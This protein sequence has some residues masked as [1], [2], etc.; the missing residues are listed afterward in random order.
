MLKSCRA[1]P[2]CRRYIQYEFK[3]P[4]GDKPPPYDKR[5]TD[6]FVRTPF[7]TPCHARYSALH[8]LGVLLGDNIAFLREEGGSRR[9]TEGARVTIDL[10]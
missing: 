2:W 7:Y 3:K 5:S 8:R 10:H 6:N 4:A 1:V 9:L